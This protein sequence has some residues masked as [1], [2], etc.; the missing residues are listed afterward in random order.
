MTLCASALKPSRTFSEKCNAEGWFTP[1][2]AYILCF[3]VGGH[4]GVNW[5]CL[6]AWLKQSASR[7]LPSWWTTHA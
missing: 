3:C 1:T 4:S 2:S 5:C 7:L 6:S